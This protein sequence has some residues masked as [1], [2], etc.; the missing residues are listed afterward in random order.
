MIDKNVFIVLKYS[1]LTA[2]VRLLDGRRDCGANGRFWL[3]KRDQL[4]QVF[5]PVRMML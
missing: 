3:R 1:L 2:R 4:R 5:E